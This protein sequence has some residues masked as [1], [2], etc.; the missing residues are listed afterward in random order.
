MTAAA[1]ALAEDV[2]E[3]LI[4]RY[5]ALGSSPGVRRQRRAVAVRFTARFGGID[6]WSSLAPAE[7]HTAGIGSRSYAAWAAV[8]H[9][10]P[11]DADYVVGT[12]AKWA[13][14]VRDRE[15]LAH[16][17]FTQM[18]VDLG[19]SANEVR[20]MWQALS[21][22]SVI[23]GI[24][25]STLADADYT[26]TSAVYLAAIERRCGSIPKI[27]STPIFGLNS[28]MFHLHRGLAPR[29]RTRDGNRRPDWEALMTDSPQL[30]ATMR[31]YLDQLAVSM[32]PGSIDAIDTTLRMFA[33]F[34]IDTFPDV[35]G[36]AGV[37][38]VHIEGFKPWLAARPN[39]KGNGTLTPTTIGMR[40]GHLQ[41]FFARII[42]WDYDDQPRRNPVMHGDKPIRN[43]ALPRFLD[44]PTS[45]KLLTAARG[46]PDAFDRLV[47]EMLARTGM[48]RGELAALTIDAVVQIGSA[49]WATNPDRETPQRPLHPAAPQPQRTVRP[50]ARTTARHAP[51]QPAVQR[52]RATRPTRTYRSCR[53]TRSDRR[54]DRP[55][56]PPPTTPHSCDSG[57]QPGHEPRSDRCAPRPQI[58]SDDHGVRQ[59]R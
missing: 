16:L 39:K 33:R 1:A 2:D 27:F 59:N 58:T 12:P 55:C 15:P 23:A 24:G 8:E 56:P 26:A 53:S 6:G 43:R 40:L 31:R 9:G 29:R 4:G 36:V 28:V 57:H 49:F 32:R 37:G 14:H 22:L 7:R 30:A 21:K 25:A 11:V 35:H 3:V 47:V 38:R 51:Q 46:L 19:F 5:V 42:G 17:E 52:P 13:D 54:R 41:A 18:A 20:L 48:R 10:Q 50:M 34:V 45:Q 44:D